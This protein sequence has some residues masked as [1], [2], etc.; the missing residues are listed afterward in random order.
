MIFFVLILLF[1]MIKSSQV[2]PA[3]T[4]MTD[5]MSIDKTNAI[6]GVFTVL[7]IFRHYSQY[8]A[9]DGIWDGPWA[10]LDSHLNQ[11][12]VAM[13]LFYS[14]YGIMESIKKKGFQYIKGFPVK[15]FLP[16]FVNFDIAVC[17]FLVV[18][19]FIHNVP[20]GKTFLWA[21]IGW[22]AIGNSNWY[23][24]VVFAIYV[25]V[26]ISFLL[27]KGKNTVLKQIICTAILTVLT[28][29]LVLFL[30]RSGQPSWYYNTAIL[31]PLG[32]WYSI[33]KDKI[34]SVVMKN[35]F[36]YAG[37]CALVAGLY[38]VSF[39]NRWKHG[40][41]GYTVW[42]VAFVLVV[43]LFTMKI[44]MQSTILTWLGKHVFSVYILQRIPMMIFNY[45]GW[46]D[47]Y[48]YM[49]LVLSILV[50]IFIAMIFDYLTGKLT[51]FYV[52]KLS[53]AQKVEG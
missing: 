11:M 42:A 29:G 49:M 43:L 6:K 47:Q 20:D 39:I 18:D 24:F 28:A 21:L 33:L 25:L 41:E 46:V 34:E 37:I 12:V 17:L 38:I 9:F 14:G 53:G 5:Y 2:S 48:K 50:T 40:I 1:I 8:V 16:V 4:F 45:L 15:R 35:D 10:T 23:M 51:S 22:K 31:F 19:I 30:I 44:S 32:C 3:G 13:F 36:I 26:C 7:I 52:G 27:L